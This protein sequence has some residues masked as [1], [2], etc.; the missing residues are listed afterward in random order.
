MY[1]EYKFSVTSIS[2]EVL[3]YSMLTI[4]NNMVFYSSKL[5]RVDRNHSQ[6][7]HTHKN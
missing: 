4:V 5:L 2:S 7:T 1:Q 6:H 3:M